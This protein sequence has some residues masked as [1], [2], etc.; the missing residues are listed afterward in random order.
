VT[1][2]ESA[3]EIVE[4]DPMFRIPQRLLTWSQGLSLMPKILTTQRDATAVCVAAN[5]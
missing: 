5:W 1:A 2:I 4:N 3:H